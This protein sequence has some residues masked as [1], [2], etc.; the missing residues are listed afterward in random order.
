MILFKIPY[1]FTSQKRFLERFGLKKII[2]NEITRDN[3]FELY[4]S[5]KRPFVVQIGAN[6]GKT[7]DPL[8]R[9]ISKYKTAGLLVEPQPDVFQK[10]KNNYKDN[11]NLKFADVA[12]GEED[13][14]I[15][16]Y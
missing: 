6:D 14:S 3:F 8:Y 9:Y 13:S 10:L 15:P 2:H 16:F 12:M 5:L 7:H 4:F 1:I 11:P